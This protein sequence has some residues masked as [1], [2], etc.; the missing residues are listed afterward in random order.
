LRLQTAVLLGGRFK[1]VLKRDSVYYVSS[2]NEVV[3]FGSDGRFV[4]KLSKIGG[5]PDE[6][7]DLSD[8]DIA[9][10]GSGR[11]I[12]VATAGG[13]CRYRL[14]GLEF[15][16]KI[17]YAGFANQLKYVNDS[18]II[19]VAPDDVTFKIL[20]MG[21][22]VR[23]EYFKKDI[24]N[25]CSKLV[26]F[27]TVG[28]KVAYQLVSANDAVVYDTATDSFSIMPIFNTDSPMQTAELNRE[29]YDKFGMFDQTKELDKSYMGIGAF[30]CY[31]D[32]VVAVTTRTDGSRHFSF[33][34]GNEVATGEIAPKAAFAENVKVD[35]ELY[36]LST[37]VCCD[38]DDGF[39]FMMPEAIENGEEQNPSLLEVRP[40]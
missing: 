29:Y 12:M 14:P 25:N 37:M 38:S 33:I 40:L 3:I 26:G 23:K 8:F 10:T 17:P 1:K 15:A 19:I 5:G 6:Y 36:Y 11:E 4:N 21:G 34:D 16:G 18:T 39:L 13:V 35:G 30:Q 24:A 32:N 2:F 22:N 27:R 9:D 31:G 28:D 20:D 7:S